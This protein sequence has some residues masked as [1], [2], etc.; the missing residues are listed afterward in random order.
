MEIFNPESNIQFMRARK[1]SLAIAS[2]LV[3]VS[4]FLIFGKGL[5]YGLDFTGG[6]LVE[7]SYEQPIDTG[8]VREAL[9]EAGF[10]GAIVQSIGGTRDVA[11]RI[12]P[13]GMGFDE[14]DEEE[15]HRADEIA[16]DVLA[17]LRAGGA[18]VTEKRHDFVG[19]QVGEQLRNDGL[20]AMVFVIIGIGAYLAIRFERRFAAAALIAE[21]HD[22]VVTVGI[23]ALVGR[24]FDMAV[25]ASVLAVVGYSVNDTVV[26]FDRV[27][28]LFRISRKSD[29]EQILNRAVNNTLSRTIV[30]SLTTAITMAALWIFGGP[31]T[32]GFAV[33]MLTGVVIGTLSSIFIANPLLL[34]MGVSKQD[35]MRVKHDDPALARRP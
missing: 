20:I 1:Y 28:E 23:I 7:V 13:K 17:A 18:Q 24:E 31:A 3:L 4:L 34:L 2:I 12:Q 22:A 8:E 35:L 6:V 21:F 5:N 19:P 29:P 26:V 10:E 16:G 27:R 33:T 32:E 14:S 25:L 9:A 11:V 30:T 15:G